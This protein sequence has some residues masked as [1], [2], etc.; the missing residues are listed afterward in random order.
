VASLYLFLGSAFC[1][2][3][4]FNKPTYAGGGLII[5]LVGIPLYYYAVRKK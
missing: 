2:F 1:G 5:T 3:L 4:I